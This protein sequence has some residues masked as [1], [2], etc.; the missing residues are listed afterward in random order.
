MLASV[1]TPR[2]EPR[3]PQSLESLVES[4][5]TRLDQPAGTMQRGVGEG[6]QKSEKGEGEGR[7]EEAEVAT[8]RGDVV[9]HR[10]G[11][12]RTVDVVGTEAGTGTVVLGGN[13]VRVRV[14]GG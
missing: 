12:G 10:S 13:G 11:S 3:E 6:V 1:P 14:E 4:R 9:S 2:I 8:P 5:S 7:E